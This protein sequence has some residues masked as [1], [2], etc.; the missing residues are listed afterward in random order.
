MLTTEH[1]LERDFVRFCRKNKIKLKRVAYFYVL[2]NSSVRIEFDVDF[3]NYFTV[4]KTDLFEQ[5]KFVF[6]INSLEELVKKLIV[7][8]FLLVTSDYKFPKS[9]RTRKLY[10]KCVKK[11]AKPEQTMQLQLFQ[12]LSEPHGFGSYEV[13]TMTFT[14]RRQYSRWMKNC[15]PHCGEYISQSQWYGYSYKVLRLKP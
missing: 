2:N 11:R 13:D 14:Q 3:N 1:Q 12:K 4:W 9:P 6:N 7:N 10:S 8:K 5:S 15:C